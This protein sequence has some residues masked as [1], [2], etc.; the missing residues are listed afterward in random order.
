[1][2]VLSSKTV[3]V[4]EHKTTKVPANK[5]VNNIYLMVDNRCIFRKFESNLKTFNTTRIKN[6][7]K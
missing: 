1:M 5:N 3:C 2:L 6:E 7:I 4:R